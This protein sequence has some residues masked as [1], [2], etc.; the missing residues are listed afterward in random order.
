MHYIEQNFI[1]IKSSHIKG[2]NVVTLEFL[3]SIGWS[4]TLTKLLLILDKNT[5]L[6]MSSSIFLFLFLFFYSP[7][8]TTLTT[9]TCSSS[10]KPIF[11][12][13]ISLVPR[14][15]ANLLLPFR[16]DPFLLYSSSFFTPILSS[17]TLVLCIFPPFALEWNNAWKLS[18]S[19]CHHQLVMP[20]PPF[21]L[22]GLVGC[23][24]KIQLFMMQQPLYTILPPRD[25]SSPPSNPDFT[26]SSSL[27]TPSHFITHYHS[28][29]KWKG[30][31]QCFPSN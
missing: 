6:L 14:K 7:L 31:Q 9:T 26:A 23:T 15:R 18:L 4:P 8:P 16:L 11:F 2:K 5:F 3:V 20:P 19:S 17:Q 29:V 1:Q 10:L 27:F 30:G 28:Y 13:P 22:C 21:Q 25:T 12:L 24:L